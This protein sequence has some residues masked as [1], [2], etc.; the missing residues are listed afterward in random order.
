[1]QNGSVVGIYTAPEIAAPVTPLDEVK[2]IAGHGLEGDR[3]F[4]ADGWDQPKKELTL[5][6]IEAVEAAN[7]DYDIGL[8]AE[9]TRRQIVTR[10]VALNHLVG[11]E[12]T[13]GDVRLRGI[14][15]N[16]PC[17]HLRK[18]SG[19]PLIKPLIHRGGLRAQILDSGTIRVG[20]EI[21]VPRPPSGE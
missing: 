17:N 12:F 4:N 13:I 15:L 18:L 19:K 6:E 9:D 2:A 20:D 5:V 16:E 11:Q 3:Y 21:T 7:R 8:T 14:K 10:G 1:M